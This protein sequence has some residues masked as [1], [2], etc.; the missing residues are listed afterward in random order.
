MSLID[1]AIRAR[2]IALNARSALAALARRYAPT[3]R[4]SRASFTLDETVTA[5]CI[6]EYVDH[7]SVTEPRHPLLTSLRQNIGTCA[8]R[9]QCALIAPYCE[10]VFALLPP[11]TADDHPYDWEIVPLIVDQLSWDDAPLPPEAATAASVAA[12]LAGRPS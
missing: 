11:H 6:W 3:T 9:E 12:I 5:L 1:H 4:A 2:R 10:R 7:A 8:L